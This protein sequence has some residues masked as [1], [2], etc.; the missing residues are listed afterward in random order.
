MV[1]DSVR[2]RGDRRRPASCLGRPFGEYGNDVGLASGRVNDAGIM[3]D[4][5]DV[6]G[7]VRDTH[8]TGKA[9]W[10]AFPE[11]L[12]MQDV[13]HL[14]RELGRICLLLG[15]E[16]QQRNESVCRDAIDDV[17][18]ERLLILDAATDIESR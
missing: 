11:L 17:V 6:A 1:V 18:L 7:L 13:E 10:D 5:R 14:A 8:V 12:L 15:N 3:R 16:A 2:D 9:R 4:S